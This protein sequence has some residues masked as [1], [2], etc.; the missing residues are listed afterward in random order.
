MGLSAS[1][2]LPALR[3]AWARLS[4]IEVNRTTPGLQR[5]HGQ[6]LGPPAPTRWDE[7]RKSKQ[8]PHTC[9]F[10][11]IQPTTQSQGNLPVVAGP[12]LSWLAQ[13]VPGPMKLLIPGQTGT[14]GH[15]TQH[16][17]HS[18]GHHTFPFPN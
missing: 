11:K 16:T 13:K 18:Q 7:A 10:P 12:G 6:E 17:P 8:P 2:E 5:G 14:T 15:P 4:P 9:P 3:T 1:P